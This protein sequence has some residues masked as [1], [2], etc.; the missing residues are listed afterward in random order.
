MLILRIIFVHFGRI[1][2][3]TRH[4]SSPVPRPVCE[5]IERRLL[6]SS[7]TLDTTFGSGG[8]AVSDLPGVSSANQL[9]AVSGGK[10]VAAGNVSTGFAMARFS[11]GGTLDT[12]F[13]VGGKILL[14]KFFENSVQ[15]LGNGEIL[16]AG[17]TGPH[18]GSFEMARFNANGTL[19]K[20][21]GHNG[22]VVGLPNLT[23][24]AEA[25]T[26]KI[27]SKGRIVVAGDATTEVGRLEF[28]G[29]VLEARFMPNGAVDTTFGGGA[30]FLQ[31]MLSPSP[32]F[33]TP[34]AIQP[35]GH[36]L[37]VLPGFSVVRF[38]ADL[39]AST[40]FNG[41]KPVSFGADLQGLPSTV[42]TL[43]NGN[44]LVGG[45]AFGNATPTSY[46]AMAEF[47]TSGSLNSGFGTG[48]VVLSGFP[49]N[50]TGNTAINSITVLP[51]GKLLA[52]GK[53]PGGFGMARYSSNGSLDTTFGSSHTGLVKATFNT[54]SGGAALVTP[55]GQYLIAGAFPASAYR[56]SF[57]LARYSSSGVLDGT[58]GLARNGYVTT[59]FP[60]AD[61]INA[62][63]TQSD[64]KILAAGINDGSF[65][66]TRF[67][68]NG[69][70]DTSFQGGSVTLPSYVAANA[71]AILPGGK[72]LVVGSQ[73]YDPLYG[74]PIGQVL[75]RFNA[76]G[77]LDNSFGGNGQIVNAG[78]TGAEELSVLASGKILVA[79]TNLYGYTLTRYNANGSID[80]TFGPT[81]SP[82]VVGNFGSSP[83]IDNVSAIAVDSTGRIVL[84]GSAVGPYGNDEFFAVRYSSAGVLDMS[85][86][87]SGFATISRGSASID[88]ANAVALVSG[89]KILLA[90]SA[91]TGSANSEFALIRL[92]AN[93]S[94]D[95]SFGSHGITLT[96]FVQ[97]ASAA[98]MAVESDGKILLAGS[99][100]SA[101][102][103]AYPYVAL[104]RYNSNGTLDT[105]FAASGIQRTS[106]SGFSSVNVDA[107]S[108]IAGGKFLV[109][110][111]VS[112]GS[113]PEFLLAR[114]VG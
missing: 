30:G 81:S 106:V 80:T 57:G 47:T 44:V 108:L 50:D 109:G 8:V 27:D 96:N 113:Y 22:L 9:I 40:S 65:S 104:A 83:V 36:I 100:G 23:E 11:A 68:V 26:F 74:L 34:E 16:A 88:A 39:S 89:G 41:G 53:G 102:G 101:S 75:V 46:F 14:P 49:R 66:L 10:Y 2:V 32:A 70:I 29:Y 60:G 13:G 64:G 103:S 7:S 105:T 20:A 56:T 18:S 71:L 48:G 15:L 17:S 85:F 25:V 59:D 24:S 112:N 84:T 110:G 12:S 91:I 97:P 38:S 76:D 21:F 61:Q 58:F 35:D 98:A 42:L 78:D 43:S 111:S 107:L 99:N 77:T 87:H 67:N 95:T 62:I 114:Y 94:L 52:V 82:G 1:I 73:T 5:F 28:V 90:G 69:S 93:G 54:E 92:N 6:L 45:A 86:G 4:A 19:D 79:S 51:G 31:A 55:A 33:G 37:A 63:V 3:E 72:I